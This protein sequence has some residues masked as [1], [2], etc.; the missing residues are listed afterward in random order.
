MFANLFRDN[1]E[2]QRGQPVQLLPDDQ[3]VVVL[4]FSASWCPPCRQFT[5]LLKTAYST[6]LGDVCQNHGR[7]MQVVFVSRD[8]SAEEFR[9]YF[10]SHHG[11]W[12]AVKFEAAALRDSLAAMFG[13]RGIPALVIPSAVPGAP[14]L[15]YFDGRQE[16]S[17]AVMAGSSS[18]SMP[19]VIRGMLN[20][21]ANR[22]GVDF[23]VMIRRALQPLKI[24]SG[25]REAAREFLAKIC[26][27]IAE[28]PT[29]DKYR[30]LKS[31]SGQIN[32]FLIDT[33]SGDAPL[34]AA[35]FILGADGNYTCAAGSNFRIKYQILD[36]LAEKVV[37]AP[38]AA[39]PVAISNEFRFVVKHANDNIVELPD[40]E[41]DLELLK[42]LIDSVSGVHVKQQRLFADLPLNR[43]MLLTSASDLHAATIETQTFKMLRVL[44]LGELSKVNACDAFPSDAEADSSA[45]ALR[46]RLEEI[47]KKNEHAKAGSI[48]TLAIQVQLSEV[49]KTQEEA[50][51]LLPATRMHRLA[52]EKCK[53]GEAFDFAFLVELVQWFKKDFFSWTDKPRCSACQAKST[54]SVSAA[55]PPTVQEARGL[56]KTVELYSCSACGSMTRFPR[57]N[58]PLA[59]LSTRTGRCG[60]FSNA[61]LLFARS[62]GYEARQ[63]HAL[64]NDHVW[65]EVWLDSRSSWVHVD[66]SEG[67][68]DRSLIYEHGWGKNYDWCIAVGKD[69]V[70][71]VTRRYSKDFP[72]KKRNAVPAFSAF[73]ANLNDTLRAHHLEMRVDPSDRGTRAAALK[74]R[75]DAE[76]AQLAALAATPRDALKE[77][78]VGRESG[79]AAWRAARGES[80]P[81]REEVYKSDNLTVHKHN[82]DGSVHSD[83]L[84]FDDMNTLRDFLTVRGDWQISE[85]KLWHCNGLVTGVECEWRND[86]AKESILGGTHL[87]NVEGMKH[88]KMLLRHGE[89]VTSLTVRSGDQVDFVGLET[90]LGNKLEV[91]NPTGGLVRFSGK[92]KD[93]EGLFGF[94]GGIGGHVHHLSFYTRTLPEKEDKK[95]LKD[96][97]IA[98]QA[99]LIAS[100]MDPLEAAIRAIKSA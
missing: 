21:W 31:T 95:S 16:L 28:H 48:L 14:A 29:E 66:P 10:R 34:L 42:T 75:A 96:R 52:V 9:D 56:A 73:V 87:A 93:G 36:R 38:L 74:A 12:L 70:V 65:V 46:L 90:N 54:E 63:V 67:V 44:L 30:S 59:L 17:Q 24:G 86:K 99:E 61:F 20:S 53:D 15:E 94:A 100:G 79:S 26:L 47:G 77:E 84:A 27:N 71:D 11:D 81:E 88:A 97:I 49:P 13:V 89:F 43:C 55:A 6:S 5:P 98:T 64:D 33:P 62:C 39:E 8:R 22:N 60:E 41:G 1:L 37:S 80:K 45:A 57:F 51:K 83:T 2:N 68:V 32:H 40:V 18:N 25:Q 19:M 91:G 85:I 92:L 78:S 82:L 58:H 23:L 69:D 76:E 50:L 72:A 7:R 3:G 4:Y 35:G